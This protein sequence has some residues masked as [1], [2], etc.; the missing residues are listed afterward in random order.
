LEYIQNF[1]ELKDKKIYIFQYP[2]GVFS[3]SSG[4]IK[5][6][7]D[8]FEFSH[9]ASTKPG[10]SGSP[11][12]LEEANEI[13]GI[14][15]QG[16][17]DKNENYGDFIWP[18]IYTLTSDY[19]YKK[20]NSDNNTYE[21]GFLNNKKEGFGIKTEPNGF[22]YI[23]Q[24][25]NDK[26]HG[27]GILYIDYEK[28]YIGDFKY[29]KIEGYGKVIY[30]NECYFLGQLK[31]NFR[32]GKGKYFNKKGELIYEGDF[33]DCKM[34]GYGTINYGKGRYYTGQI[35]AGLAN[36]KGTFY[37]K[38]GVIYEGDLVDHIYSGYGKLFFLVENTILD[39]L[40]IMNQMEL[41]NYIIRKE[42]FYMKVII[43][44]VNLMEMGKD[45]LLM[46]HII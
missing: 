15:K 2:K 17:L 37:D 41:E 34:E 13:I 12:I 22:C 35:K 32:I 20:I 28:S 45:I 7:K 27:K 8:Y 36:G 44:M 46:E 43:W 25:E 24:F 11:I 5:E 38:K 10:S 23:G 26:F 18:V 3:Y 21:G 9:L 31:D 33:V 42:N 39:N 30:K 14:H 4:T 29:G 40:R 16:N 1:E 19:P 6:I